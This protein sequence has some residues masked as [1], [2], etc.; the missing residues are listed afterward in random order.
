MSDKKPVYH[1]HGYTLRPATSEDILMSTAWT[2]ADPWHANT[3]NPEF[4]L[5]QSPGIES[6]ILEDAEG[7]VF[8]F[9]MT[10]AVRLDIQ[11][12]PEPPEGDTRKRV[13]D[14]LREGFGW[15]AAVL[16]LSGVHE[17]I[18]KSENPELIRSAEKRL[19]FRYSKG[20]LVHE[21]EVRKPA[22][23]EGDYVRETTEQT[24]GTPT[25]RDDP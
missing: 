5:D 3:T 22:R 10:R 24:N 15:L 1:F 17:V 9:R 6:Y 8:F 7:P 4:W 12:P 2:A 23:E 21:L 19:G 16:A 14:G 25:A 13:R 11:F 18:F 20:E